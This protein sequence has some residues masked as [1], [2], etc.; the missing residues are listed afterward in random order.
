ML[1]EYVSLLP[2]GLAV[3][4]ALI[5]ILIITCNILVI[6]TFQRMRKYSLQQL[7]MMA[8]VGPDLL[9][10]IVHSISAGM[11]ANGGISMDKYQCHL[12]GVITYTA[13]GATTTIHTAMCVDRWFLIFAPIKYRAFKIMDK[14]RY[15][16]YLIITLC[17]LMPV[18]LNFVLLCFNLV[19]FHFDPYFPS[20]VL[21]T[22][23][24]NIAGYSINGI[25]FVVIPIFTTGF[26]NVH[27]ILKVKSLRGSNRS[28]VCKS[29]RIVLIT[30]MTYYVCWLPTAVF[31]AW[32]LFDSELASRSIFFFSTQML[33]ANSAMSLP[34]YLLTNPRFRSQFCALIRRDER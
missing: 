10:F 30:V 5:S 24:E 15:I 2:R 16:V 17:Y 4:I 34:I 27:F 31:V 9:M 22:D 28:R 19:D 14:S 7:Y 3:V 20:C 8:L 32:S 18:A 12:L 23:T 1:T 33:A 13:I 26:T 21:T 25:F 11:T 6:L 29:V